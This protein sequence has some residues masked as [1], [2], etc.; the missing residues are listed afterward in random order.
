MP[1]APGLTNVVLSLAVGVSLAAAVGFRVFVPLLVLGAA[2]RA[3]W[4]SLQPDFAWLASDGGLTALAVATTVEVV[5]YYIP[6]ID[7]ALDILAAPAAIVAGVLATAAV[8]ADLPAPMRWALAVVAGG[9]TA[10]FV[11]GL[12]SI[13]RLKSTG[14][15]LGLANPFLATFE[16]F[17]ATGVALLAL[18]APIAAIL[19]V[20]AIALL[21]RRL[22][23]RQARSIRSSAAT[24]ARIE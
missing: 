4:I 10:G 5:A 7:N 24:P 11:Q 19:I 21:I 14:L 22:K 16:L 12:T 18:A 17:G 6:T 9:G 13:A 3:G 23:R 15:T 1:D 8:S 2:G 20:L